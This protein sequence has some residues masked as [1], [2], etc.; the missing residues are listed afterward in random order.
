MK[1]NKLKQLSGGMKFLI[2]V[3]LLYLISYLV[4]SSYVKESFQNF[5]ILLTNVAPMIT[6]VF[7]IMFI[8]NIFL[9]PEKINKHLGHD[10][11]IKG[12]IYSIIAGI[13]IPSPPYVVYPLLGDLKKSGMKTSLIVSFLYNRNLQVT[14]LPVMAFYFGIPFT[15]VVSIYV[16]IFAIISGLI[17]E[18]VINNQ[19]LVKE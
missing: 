3:T 13:L 14:F 4:S 18:K 19:T 6:I 10:S 16:F 17:L 5:I 9:K 1:Q 15:I 2:V 7:V 8:M 12:W 11:G